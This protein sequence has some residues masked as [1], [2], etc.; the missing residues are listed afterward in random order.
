[1]STSCI[2]VAKGLEDVSFPRDYLQYTPD[3][4]VALVATWPKIKSPCTIFINEQNL[5]GSNIPDR[6]QKDMIF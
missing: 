6:I 4:L 5:R 1:M 2:L 3:A